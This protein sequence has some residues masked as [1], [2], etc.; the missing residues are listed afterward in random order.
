LSVKRAFAILVVVVASGCGGSGPTSWEVHPDGRIGPLQID[1]STE[2]QIRDFA[3]NPSK[4]ERD[5]WPGKKGQFGHSLEYRCGRKCLTS[6]SINNATGR[7]SDYWTQSPRFRTER[8]SHVGMRATRAARLEGRKLRLGCGFPR[9]LYLRSGQ[10]RV[11]VLAIWK[12]HVDS[13]GY[14][15]P[16]TVYYDGL[17]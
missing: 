16:H 8:G 7:L 13:I 10:G 5:F 2:A 4:V 17:C 1:V 9:Y 14:L 6:Y 11:F 3:G 12:G 15:G